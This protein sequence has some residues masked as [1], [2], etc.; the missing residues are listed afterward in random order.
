MWAQRHKSDEK[1]TNSVVKLK[2]TMSK[3]FDSRYDHAFLPYLKPYLHLF[4]L[5]HE[6]VFVGNPL[7]GEWAYKTT[8]QRPK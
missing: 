7:L 4:L 1:T 8:K 3:G 5:W 2:I 6:S